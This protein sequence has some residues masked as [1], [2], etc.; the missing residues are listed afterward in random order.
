MIHFYGMPNIIQETPEEQ[1][2]RE[3]K[4]AEQARQRKNQ[5]LEQEDEDYGYLIEAVATVPSSRS[6]LRYL[7]YQLF[8]RGEM[9]AFDHDANWHIRSLMGHL[10]KKEEQRTGAEIARLYGRDIIRIRKDVNKLQMGIANHLFS[11]N[12]LWNASGKEKQLE[13]IILYMY[14][15]PG[16]SHARIAKYYNMTEE[17][18]ASIIAW[19]KELTYVR[20]K[21]AMLEMDILAHQIVVYMEKHPR[22]SMSDIYAAICHKNSTWEQFQS[23]LETYHMVPETEEALVTR[24]TSMMEEHIDW[25]KFDLARELGWSEARVKQFIEKHGLPYQYKRGENKNLHPEE[26]MTFMANHPGMTLR[27]LAAHYGVATTNMSA[28]LKKNGIMKGGA[29]VRKVVGKHPSGRSVVIQKGTSE[30]SYLYETMQ[31]SGEETT[32]QKARD[33]AR[34]TSFTEEEKQ[35]GLDIGTWKWREFA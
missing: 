32:W 6:E 31:G 10:F 26:I 2:E 3:F 15:H 27:K 8:I 13:R 23:I 22:A 5:A 12:L 7:V 21:Y 9:Q 17:Q 30:K 24:I 11:A 34:L 19:D 1:A 18:V 4:E 14:A 29:K 16:Y 20:D 33:A 28:Y 35:Q 25:T